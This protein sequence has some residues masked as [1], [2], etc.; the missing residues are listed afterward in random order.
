MAVRS[1]PGL[2]VQG[3]LGRALGDA[4]L[5]RRLLRLFVGQHADMAH[6]LSDCVR[7]RDREGAVRLAHALR[8]AALA[9]CIEEVGERSQV[10]EQA[11]IDGADFSALGSL[12]QRLDDAV[13]VAV[14][15]IDRYLAQSDVL[16]G[17][18]VP[19]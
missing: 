9:L 8:G 13:Q 18:G 7:R 11:V 5:Y 19:A 3:G 4:Q 17:A 10:I 6:R 2:D 16:E 12:V 1:A 14:G 15:S